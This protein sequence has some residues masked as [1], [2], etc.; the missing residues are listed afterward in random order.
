MVIPPLV[1]LLFAGRGFVFPLP[2]MTLNFPASPAEHPVHGRR[3][4]PAVTARWL[5]CWLALAACSNVCALDE[6]KPD[7]ARAA[8]S[9][10]FA[11]GAK[12]RTVQAEFEQLRNLRS[13]RRP[14][15]KEGRIWMEKDTG[16]LRWQVGEP[17]ELLV[18]RLRDGTTTVLDEKRKE[19][20]VWSREAL[21][22][23]E[24]DG[25]G[26][27]FAMLGAMQHMSLADF[28]KQFDLD[29]GLRDPRDAARWRFDWRFKDARTALVVLKL[30]L[31]VHIGDGTL[32][33]FTMHMR[34]GSSLSTVIRSQILNR[35]IPSETFAV[36]TTGYTVKQGGDR[37]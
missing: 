21:A 17:P 35:P 31:E 28:D 6:L 10:W 23:A 32:Q 11:A 5:V 29:A 37:P 4:M 19:A 2:T 13:V 36:D 12:V 25:G 3:A 14:L 24:T 27:A 8:L 1:L 18:C 22:G 34:D 33:S 20:R 16:L 7:A 9:Q 15:R 26:Q 30:S